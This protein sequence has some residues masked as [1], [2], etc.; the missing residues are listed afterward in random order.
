MV[1]AGVHAGAL[2][3]FIV[4]DLEVSEEVSEGM[5]R[6]HAPLAVCAIGEL[7]DDFATWF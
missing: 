4:G 3:A 7:K 2:Y 5:P 6:D 1:D